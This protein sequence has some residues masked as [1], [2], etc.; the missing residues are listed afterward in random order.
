MNKEQIFETLNMKP[1]K[2]GGEKARLFPVL[3][4]TSKEGRA[5]SIFLACL[6]L[7]P[8]FANKVLA[9]LGRTVGKRS[10]V[11]CVTE[12][13]FDDDKHNRPDGLIGVKTGSSVWRSLV[14]FK[15]GGFLEKDQVERYLRVA[16]TAGLDSVITI[17]NDIVPDPTYSPVNVSGK[18]TRSVSLFHVSWMQ[19][20]THAQILL[21]TNALNDADHRE[22]LEE[23]IRFLSHKSTGIK[24]FTQMP[25]SWGACVDK[26]RS[27]GKLQRRGNEE[28]DVVNGWMQEER[29]LSFIL[30]QSTYGY[31]DVKRGRAEHKDGGKVIEK[32][33]ASLIDENELNTQLIVKDAAAPIAVK[34]LLLSRSIHVSMSLNAPKD[35]SRA[36]AAINWL[37]RQIPASVVDCEIVAN[38]PGRTPPTFANLEVV[39]ND[40]T[41]IT[42]STQS[43]MP[44]TFEV[45]RRFELGSKFNSRKGI[46]E[47]I[48]REVE[49]FYS[50][51]GSHLVEWVPSPRTPKTSSVAEDIVE[52]STYKVDHD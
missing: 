51:I 2:R 45:L 10:K 52:Q 48:E 11:Y 5:A 34:L 30:S 43:I 35:K 7:V 50:E 38:W 24:G 49:K 44:H 8:E 37:V 6:A 36:T 19:I 14:E 9:P 31:C 39:K 32:H 47:R 27:G 18:L 25:S 4:E 42:Q 41:S 17:S 3:S 29:E 46:I 33:L 40:P 21:T 28:L 16:R 13:E 15:V 26:L 12:I 23:F 22:L 20:F 1:P